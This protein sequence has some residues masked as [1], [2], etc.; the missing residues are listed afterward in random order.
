MEQAPY[1]WNGGTTCHLHSIVF[2]KPSP[3]S[4]SDGLYI[5]LKH[6]GHSEYCGAYLGTKYCGAEFAL[7]YLPEVEQRYGWNH[8]KNRALATWSGRWTKAK[9]K[10]A[11]QLCNPRREPRK[12]K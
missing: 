12:F 5:L 11:E 2:W 1:W 10:R 9:Q 4:A 6:I 7:F 8:N 3:C